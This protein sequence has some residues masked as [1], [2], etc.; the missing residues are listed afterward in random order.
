MPTDLVIRY[1]GA[2]RSRKKEKVPDTFSPPAGITAVRK[3][4]GMKRIPVLVAM[5]GLF[6]ACSGFA[7]RD[8]TK[9]SAEHKKAPLKSKISPDLWQKAQE[10][11]L[12]RV[13][14]DLDVPVQP[15]SKLTQEGKNAQRHAI[16][17]AQRQ[18]LA[19]LAGTRH[20]RYRRLITVPAV[21]LS[22]GIDALSVLGRSALVKKVSEAKPLKSDLEIREQK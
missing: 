22:V 15:E 7:Q 16:E 5:L 18:L 21:G 6:V 12:I 1:A 20:E 4:K 11:G 19:E 9:E 3:R 14:I 17:T 13:I 2:E 8:S 10:K